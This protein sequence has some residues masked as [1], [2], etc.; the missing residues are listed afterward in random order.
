MRKTVLSVLVA[1][2]A[3]VLMSGVSVAKESA[4]AKAKAESAVTKGNE[5]CEPAPVSKVM[6]TVKSIDPKKGELV[7][8]G[9]D[10]K[11][12]TFKITKDQGK[13]VKAGDKVT[14]NAE[15]DVAKRIMKSRGGKPPVGC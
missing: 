2:F 10:G 15:K 14:V 12:V 4:K 1:L 5:P 7:L 13:K 6:G 3:V 8:T 9:E 11:D